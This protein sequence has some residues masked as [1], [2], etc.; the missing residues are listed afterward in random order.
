VNF[1]A[2]EHYLKDAQQ[3]S[4]D[5]ARPVSS[6]VGSLSIIMREG[7]SNTHIEVIRLSGTK[8]SD[9]RSAPSLL[10]GFVVFVTI[11]NP[12]KTSFAVICN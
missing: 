6:P 7:L 10:A 5:G 12:C 9:Y 8:Q 4:S 3:K 1:D 2:C 11:I